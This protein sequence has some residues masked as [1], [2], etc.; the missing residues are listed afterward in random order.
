MHAAQVGGLGLTLTAANRVVIVDPSWNPSVDNQAVDRAYRIG[1]TRNVVVYRLITCGTVEEKIYR[2]QVFKGGLSRAGTEE[3]AQFRYF[4]QQQLRD[5]FQVTSEG[6][7]ASDTQRLLHQHHAAQRLSDPDLD[8]HLH[9]LTSLEGY[10]GG[11]P[12]LQH[13]TWPG[14]LHP[15]TQGVF[16]ML[17]VCDGRHRPTL[18][19]MPEPH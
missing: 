10:T 7:L 1:Q 2:K 3:G 13:L 8:Q 18:N 16:C 6:L 5:L 9:F 4:T 12:Q 19:F 11:S 17:L 15:H 14:P